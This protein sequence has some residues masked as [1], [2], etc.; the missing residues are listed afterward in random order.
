[1]FGSG[2]GFPHCRRGAPAQLRR[3]GPPLPRP[4]GAALIGRSEHPGVPAPGA[5]GARCRICGSTTEAGPPAR[6]LWLL[7]VPRQT[8]TG[9]AVVG[10]GSPAAA[11]PQRDPTPCLIGRPHPRMVPAPGVFDIA[12]RTPSVAALGG[13]PRAPS[14]IDPVSAATPRIAAGFSTAIGRGAWGC[15]GWG[16]C[17]PPAPIPRGLPPLGLKAGSGRRHMSVRRPPTPPAGSPSCA[18]RGAGGYTVQ[19]RGSQG[20]VAPRVCLLK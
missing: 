17:R 18:N 7:K 15:R 2:A 20:G 16:G 10:H 4:S 8:W 13:G 14:D 12:C 9:S 5:A 1:M 3:K 6:A 11:G 19:G